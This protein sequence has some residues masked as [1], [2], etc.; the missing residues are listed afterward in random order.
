LI[1]LL[2]VLRYS[3]S[4]M[5]DLCFNVEYERHLQCI[6]VSNLLREYGLKILKR[7]IKQKL[8]NPDASFADLYEQPQ[9]S[10][11]TPSA[12]WTPA[13]GLGEDALSSHCDVCNYL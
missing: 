6:D 7:L 3:V 5:E 4:I 8:G 10:R 2:L 11:S 12:L 1:G 9:G 13:C